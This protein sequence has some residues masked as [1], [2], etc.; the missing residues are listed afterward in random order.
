MKKSPKD[1]DL[2]TRAYIA[3]IQRNWNDYRRIYN[4]LTIE[5]LISINTAWHNALP[6]QNYAKIGVFAS[7]FKAVK[8]N[9]LR[10]VE[11]GCYE[12][13]LAHRMIENYP[14]K[15]TRWVGYDIDHRAIDAINLK[16]PNLFIRSKKTFEGVKLNKWFWEVDVST[17]D[18]FV[19]SH[20]LEHFNDKQAIKILNHV[21]V[22]KY[23]FLE[24]PFGGN[25]HNFRGS[26]VLQAKR[27]EVENLL[28]FTHRKMYADI[29]EV[30]RDDT[31]YSPFIET[32]VK[33]RIWSC[34]WEK[35]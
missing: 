23:L 6:S 15:I 21:N 2:K 28:S 7:M 13:W 8:E 35:K 3:G 32:L 25:W 19:C 33:N 27:D 14:D 16:T 18:V 26:H 12:G 29:E 22:C 20:T 31:M 1:V 5:D 9:N 17:Y 24:I 34:A 11:L 4:E 10:V 30:E